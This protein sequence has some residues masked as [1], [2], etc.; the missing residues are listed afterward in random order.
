M[1]DD[2]AFS[3]LTAA[4]LWQIPLPARMERDERFHVMS[5]G[6]DNRVRRRGV[7]GH[8]GLDIRETEWI[9][10]LRV[11]GAAD[12]W[13]DL[14]EMTGMGRSF[15]LDDLIVA[16][17]AVAQRLGAIEPLR[18][19]LDRRVRPR[20]RL[21]LLPA[22]KEVRLGS[23]SA[24]E[25]RVR[26]MFVRAGLPEPELNGSVYTARGKL[27]GMADV[28]WREWRVAGEYQGSAFH[29]SPEQKRANRRRRKRF[30]A[31]GIRVGWIWA[32]DM[33]TVDARKACVVRF[34]GLLGIPEYELDLN[35]CEPPFFSLEDWEAMIER[36]ARR[37]NR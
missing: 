17:D 32:D 37:R 11:V 28:L 12:T 18:A 22:L 15:G 6:E 5:P 23:L 31:D 21:M 3:H 19:A 14:G 16:G 30:R 26:L 33:R 34:A 9:E 27:I 7:V 24:M 20:G 35:A 8:R 4:Q 1:P 25:T 13:V 29:S 10:G 2:V 36:R